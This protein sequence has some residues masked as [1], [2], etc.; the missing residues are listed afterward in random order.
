MDTPRRALIDQIVDYVK[1]L[2]FPWLLGITVAVFLVDL[3]AI[4]P[5]PFIDEIALAVMAAVLASLKRR[6]PDAVLNGQ[7]PG[8]DS[9]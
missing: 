5:I 3:L 4:D 7:I 2:R 1:G 9:R 6:K 8:E